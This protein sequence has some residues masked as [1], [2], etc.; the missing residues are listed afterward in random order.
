MFPAGAPGIALLLLRVSLAA[1]VLGGGPLCLDRRGP[2]LL[3]LALAGLGILL[4]LGLLTPIVSLSFFCIELVTFL[5]ASNAEWRFFMLSCL[6]AIGLAMLG[7]GAYSF[8]AKLFGRREIVFPP[9]NGR[10]RR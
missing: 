2:D 9:G 5:L 10:D 6:V 3:C 4:C 8:D 7:P 1:A